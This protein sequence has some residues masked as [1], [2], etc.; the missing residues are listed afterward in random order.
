VVTA[1]VIE[2]DRWQHCERHEQLDRVLELTDLIAAARGVNQCRVTTNNRQ[3]QAHCTIAN[4][5]LLTVPPTVPLELAPPTARASELSLT[6]PSEPGGIT[7]SIRRPQH[8]A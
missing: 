7:T 2:D 5:R 3:C 8:A 4:D 6:M 1:P